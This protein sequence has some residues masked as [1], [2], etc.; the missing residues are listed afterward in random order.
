MVLLKSN[1]TYPKS[2]DIGKCSEEVREFYK[3]SL[4]FHKAIYSKNE[5][6]IMEII[7]NNPTLCHF[8]NYSNESAPKIALNC[9]YVDIYKLLLTHKIFLGRHETWENFTNFER[10][11]LREIHFKH[12]MYLPEK[13]LHDLSTNSRVAHDDPN[14][15]AKRNLIEYAFDVLNTNPFTKIILMTVAASKNFQILFDFCRDSVHLLDPTANFK[16]KGLFY[17][18]GRIYISAWLLMLQSTEN[19]TFGTLAHELCH[20]AMKLVYKNMAKPYYRNDRDSKDKFE[21]IS[22]ICKINRG[23]EPIIDLVF[24]EYSEKEQHAELIVRVPHLAALYYDQPEKLNDVKE[25]F[26]E[27]FEYYEKLVVP[28]MQKLLPKIEAKNQIKKKDQIIL[29]YKALLYIGGFI[30]IIGIIIVM[31]TFGGRIYVY[32]EL[33]ENDKIL[34]KKTNI[35]YKNVQVRFENLFPGNDKVYNKLTSEHIFQMINGVTLN[36]N[37]LNLDKEINHNWTSLAENLRIKVLNYN[38]TFQDVILKFK[39]LN[40]ESSDI[41]KCLSSEEIIDILDGNLFTIETNSILEPDYFIKRIFILEHENLPKTNHNHVWN[42]SEIIDVYNKMKMFLISAEAGTGKS[43]TMKHFKLQIKNKFPLRWISY[44]DLKNFIKF[45]SNSKNNQ[46]LTDFYIAD[47]EN[48]KT[49]KLN[50][51]LNLLYEILDLKTKSE[52]E[53]TLFHKLFMSGKVTFLWDSID[54]VYK[55]YSQTVL[56]LMTYILKKSGNSQIICT[57]PIYSR[58]LEITFSTQSYKLTFLKSNQNIFLSRFLKSRVAPEKLN[59][60]INTVENIM[61]SDDDDPTRP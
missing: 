7:N 15:K 30:S 42:F 17:Y 11:I 26:T 34:V 16:M 29:K 4:E 23:K 13:Y 38:F 57:R 32:K 44:I 28:E 33:S 6:K 59:E 47:C 48:Q 19:Q 60:T 39:D 50:Q 22:K 25:S 8:Y 20:F 61:K 12:S 31:L 55:L 35:L 40:Q 14:V 43:V 52:F 46:N 10:K 27:L 3:I 45:F 5:E 53:K 51:Y 49:F 21:E 41:F 18:S 24:E 2:F 37:N 56:K 54:E 58:D 1:L 36:F 9:K